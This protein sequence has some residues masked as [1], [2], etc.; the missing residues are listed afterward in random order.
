[1]ASSKFLQ[2]ENY[3]KTFGFGFASAADCDA[4]QKLL[5][6]QGMQVNSSL[7]TEKKKCAT[8]DMLKSRVEN[9]ETSKEAAN[10]RQKELEDQNN[11]L[12]TKNNILEGEVTKMRR[13]LHEASRELQRKDH[14]QVN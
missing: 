12:A 13:L 6:G 1:M 8:I 5:K 7:L 9:L 10:V 4:F 11:A 14:E 3:G 2:L